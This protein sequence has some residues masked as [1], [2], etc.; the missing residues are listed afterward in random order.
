MIIKHN[1]SL[2]T[3]PSLY[4]QVLINY[5]LN[6]HLS[7]DMDLWHSLN[8]RIFSNFPNLFSSKNP[9]SF[10]VRTETVRTEA[11]EKRIKE[12]KS[13]R[14]SDNSISVSEKQRGSQ[15]VIQHLDKKSLSLPD[16]DQFVVRIK[17]SHTIPL[18]Q[19]RSK[20]NLTRHLLQLQ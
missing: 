5:F 6:V 7:T 3:C 18:P 20:L 16:Q 11:D 14:V 12:N 10:Q 8:I 2:V 9:T 15:A 19:Q 17:R 13:N 1:Y 4:V